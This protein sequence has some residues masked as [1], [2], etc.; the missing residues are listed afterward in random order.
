MKKYL[1][2][3]LVAAVAFFLGQ[4]IWH[5]WQTVAAV[6]ITPIGGVSLAIAFLL[7]LLAHIVA[8]SVWADILNTLGQTVSR[9]WGVKVYLKT[10]LAKYLP[11]NIWHFYGRF[12]ACKE[13]GIPGGTALLSILL[14][15]LLMLAAAL[16]IS[17]GL[18]PFSPI[19]SLLGLTIVL[20]SIHPR[21]LNPLLKQVGRIKRE[22]LAIANIPQLQ[23]YPLRPLLG[24]L[25]F[26]ILR[27]TGFVVTWSSIHPI[28]PDQLPS[29]YSSFSL[30][31]LLGLVIPGLPGGLGVFE[32]AIVTLL[33]H[34]LNAGELLA[35]VGLYRLV[36]TG[37]EIVGAGLAAK[38]PT[39]LEFP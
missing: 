9:L 17:I 22:K 27:G 18:A 13:R 36:S 35:I 32:A 31:W 16:I 7:S 5:N 37:A 4:A 39:R 1:R 14:E 23:Q 15:P 20:I 24:E 38:L 33:Q 2:W 25:I 6:R 30:A 12:N 11:G 19:F 10:N 34:Q 21:C 28:V 8:G 3:V 29:L 26:L